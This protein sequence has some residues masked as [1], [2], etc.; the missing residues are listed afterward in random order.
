[1]EYIITLIAI[2]G[3]ILFFFTKDHGSKKKPE[4]ELELTEEFNDILKI[5]N[6]TSESVFI[7]GKAGTGKSSLLRHFIKH[8]NKKY[9]I[10]APTGVAALNVG[11]QTI[12][13]FFKFPPAVIHPNSIQTDYVRNGLFQNLQ[14]VIIDEV[15]M[16]RCDLMNGIDIA[17]RKNR[18]KIDLPF[19]GIQMVFIGDLFQL[20]PVL[21]STDRQEI[22]SKYKSQYFFDAPVFQNFKYHFK[23]LTRIFRQSEGEI[24]FKNL[25]NN[26]RVNAVQFKDMT[27]LNSRHRD[28]AGVQEN[29]IFLT[30][31]KNIARN[32]N[33]EKLAAL[34]GIE[35]VYTGKLS[36]KYEVLKTLRDEEIDEKLPAPYRLKLKKYA[37]IMMLRNDPGK[38]WVNGSLGKVDK[39]EDDAIWV[40]ILGVSYK[41]ELNTWREALYVFNPQTNEI[42]ANVSAEFE[43]FPIQL[44]Y[45]MT[46][47]KSQ[48]KTFD[49]ITVDIGTGAFA[50]G[51]IYVA[52]S[53]CTSLSGIVLNNQINNSDIIVDPKVVEFYK[54]N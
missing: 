48:G 36:G 6:E 8:T 16:V 2:G 7:T 20:P 45:A 38:R 15:S 37:Q 34:S 11:G 10:L 27:L 35:K 14:I 46:I 25:L 42:E 30:T 3:I 32:I 5:L 9:V 49:N 53:R 19:G 22:L 40:S 31:R 12:H 50:H 39:L 26:V 44:S 17:L 24:E 28:N 47:H 33:L 54:A 18:N 21:M 4:P 23:E 29:S 41:V 51:Q 1:M 43:Q 13:S 52:L